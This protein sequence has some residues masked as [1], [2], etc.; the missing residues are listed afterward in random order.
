MTDLEILLNKRKC[1]QLEKLL[2]FYQIDIE[3][4][5]LEIPES[6]KEKLED[7]LGHS[8]HLMGLAKQQKVIQVVNK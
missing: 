5:P 2:Y 1:G 4:A 6:F 8:K 3:G 7:W